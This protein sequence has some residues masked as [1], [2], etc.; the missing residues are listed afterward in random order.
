MT[1][2]LI[3]DALVLA[4]CLAFSWQITSV[5]FTPEDEE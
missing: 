3:V 2:D 5:W 1:P 4:I